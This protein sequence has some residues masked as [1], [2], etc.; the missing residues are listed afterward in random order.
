MTNS[1]RGVDSLGILIIHEVR[2]SYGIAVA[3]TRQMI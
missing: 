3:A 1:G 2:L